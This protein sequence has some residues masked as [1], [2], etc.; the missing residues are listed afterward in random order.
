MLFEHQETLSL[1]SGDWALEQSVESPILDGDIQ[2]PAGHC[3]GKVALDDPEFG[4][5]IRGPQ[6][7]SS[8]LNP[9]VIL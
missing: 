1:M 7:F 9:S 2:K 4:G 6:E 5:W 3:S 8:N